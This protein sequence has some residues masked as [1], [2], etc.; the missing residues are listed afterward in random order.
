MSRSC[1]G[2]GLK[3][4]LNEA[5]NGVAASVSTIAVDFNWASESQQSER[6]PCEESALR[7]KSAL[8]KQKW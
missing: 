7:K 3:K 8:K 4:G 6:E 5:K 2:K 1:R